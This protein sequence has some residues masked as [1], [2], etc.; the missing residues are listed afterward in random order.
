VAAAKRASKASRPARSASSGRPGIR[1]REKP[2]LDV[3][4]TPMRLG[5]AP[6]MV[7]WLRDPTVSANLGLRATP[8]LTRTR[9]FISAAAASPPGPTSEAPCP[10][11]ILLG[12]R[13]VGTVV[14]DHVDRHLGTA[15]LHIYVGD[16]AARGHGV[17]QRAV[18]LAVALAFGELA[19]H[20]VWLTVH[21]RNQAAIRAY[22]A[23]GFA[24]E[25]THRGEF[26]LGEER[27]DQLYMGVL[28]GTQNPK[29]QA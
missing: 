18:A 12:G 26:L 28:R 15:R 29:T 4:L 13:H 10:R 27:L 16:P 1:S 20:K 24:V 8:T 9:A 22:I 25:G 5:H 23:A 17:G 21:V 11:A 19:L 2:P 6:A 14:L 3:T 7:R